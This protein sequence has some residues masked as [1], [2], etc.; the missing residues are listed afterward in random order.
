ME[1]YLSE[2][3]M[4]DPRPSTSSYRTSRFVL[5]EPEAQSTPGVQDQVKKSGSTTVLDKDGDLD[6]TRNAVPPVEVVLTVRHFAATNLGCVG[7]QVLV[8]LGSGFNS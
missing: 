8:V 6:P 2:V 4:N 1:L 5:R 7:L 3:H